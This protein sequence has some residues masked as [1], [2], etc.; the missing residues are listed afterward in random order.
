MRNIETPVIRV[1]FFEH[2]QMQRHFPVSFSLLLI[3]R[4]WLCADCSLFGQH[5]AGMDCFTCHD[6]F[7]MAGTVY[8]DSLATTP[9]PDVL[10]VLMA[11]DG[12]EIIPPASNSDGNIAA[13]L[14]PAGLYLV[15]V[16]VV[17]SRT[18]HEL[19]VQESCNRCHVPG[20]NGSATRTKRMHS[21]HTHLAP[22]NNCTLCHHYPASMVLW[23]L[24]TP[25]VLHVQQRSPEL[26]GSKVIML[27]KEYPFDPVQ[28]SVVT[29]RPDIF[30]PG[31]FSAFDVILTVAARENIPVEYHWDAQRKTHFITSLNGVPGDYWYHFSYDAGSGNIGEITYR[32]AHR[33]DELLWKP[34]TWVQ[35]VTGENLEEIKAEYLEEIQRE[36]S[37]GQVVPEVRISINPSL[38]KGNLPD[39]DRRTVQRLFQNVKVT[40]HNLRGSNT[41]AYF[42]RPFQPGVTTSI[43]VLLSLQDLGEL[44]LVTGV[45]YTYFNGNWID[46]HYV[47]ALG[48]PGVGT[49]HASGRQGF[50]YVT[51]N[52]SFQRL[53]NGA[54]R[55]FHMHSDIAV[56]HAPDFTYWRW[57]ELGNPYYEASEP[58]H[59][60]GAYKEDYNND[61]NVNIADVIAL[62]L[63][64]MKD[65]SNPVVDY[66]G[67]GA[68]AITD[69]IM[70]L[71]NILKDSLTPVEEQV[72]TTGAE[73]LIAEDYNALAR[74]FNLHQPQS[75]PFNREVSFRFNI[76]E[77][78]PVSLKVFDAS[79]QQVA[80]PFTEQ[81][82][83]IGIH[84]VRWRPE[85]HLTGGT[86]YLVMRYGSHVQTR[87]FSYVK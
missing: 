11:P 43:D 79:G 67:D 55:K 25:G 12:S 35:V 16:G 50:V 24:R 37:L 19:P 38:Y 4:F 39:S 32:R 5:N 45:H 15:T 21:L 80:A 22:D 64:A 70:L 53:P 36:D 66:S 51:N 18:W 30:A 77:P 42:S 6:V 27:G 81:V 82:N 54:D 57:I 85:N 59:V 61:G 46:A 68:W 41:G 9:Q 62:L 2:T 75:N 33:W 74:G 72:V 49:A 71:I 52:G 44:D 76:F 31:F 20:G 26:P 83:D 60:T 3:L 29:V 56:L 63:L 1:F 69:A 73:L 23:Q 47:V 40:A 65:P 14:V 17:T 78:G 87:S 10:V 58:A 28:D 34:G 48:F 84:E 8:A 7:S 13:P 86:Y